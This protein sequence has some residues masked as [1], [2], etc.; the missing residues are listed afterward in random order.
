MSH[1]PNDFSILR[2][3]VLAGIPA[4]LAAAAAR[5]AF[6]ADEAAPRDG[7]AALADY[8]GVY[9]TA[10]GE[11][12]GIDRFINDSGAGVLLFADY[13]TSV[14]RS[15]FAQ[16]D[17][18]FT[19]GPG[20]AEPAPVELTIQFE[21]NGQ[22]AIES[23]ALTA[24]DG[25]RTVAEKARGRDEDVSFQ[26]EDA[27]L[28]GTLLL[29]EGPGPHPA[30]VL[31]HGSGPLT[32][33]SFGP[34]PRFFNSLGLAV[35]IYDKRGTGDST[36]RR[37][38]A[39]T[40]TP[41]TLWPAFYPDDIAAD[42][43][44]AL[45]YLQSRPEI[46]AARIGFWGSSEG[47][48]LTTQVAAQAQDVAFVINSSGFMGPLWRTILYQGEAR[49][50]AAGQPE[51]DIERAVALNRLWM[52]VGWTGRGFEDFIAQRDAARDAGHGEW[53]FYNGGAFASAEQLRWTME[54]IMNFDPVPGVRRV[55]CPA[56][57][58]FGAGD[59]L[60]D[61][62]NT[63]RLMREALVAGGNMDASTAII[64]N[65]GHSLMETPSGTRMAPGV[66]DTLRDWLTA[67][68]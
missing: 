15:L 7:F 43:L 52:E 41:E 37:L 8:C 31:L 53:L 4:A 28:S 63:A 61:T 48:M 22:G 35:L 12:V 44:A 25:T 17:G 57:G 27:T 36:G 3:T 33:Y 65:A 56:L 39:S 2:R 13:R 45:R 29:P 49:L 42:A 1:D 66:F 54:H 46:G 32:R 11:A 64:P 20:F 30:I 9:R 40:G 62:V 59:L 5:N 14:V 55:A 67:R 68:L 58:V 60:T 23:A 6:G 16:P 51:A 34:Y 21:R 26:Q 18:G 24:A 38:D 50:R 47:G 10:G 19:M